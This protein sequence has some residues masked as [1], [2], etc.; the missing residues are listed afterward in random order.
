MPPISSTV[1]ANSKPVYVRPDLSP[2]ERAMESLLLKER[3]SLIEKGVARQ[4]KITNQAYLC[5]TNFIPTYKINNCNA[6]LHPLLLQLKHQTTLFPLTRLL[7]D[8]LQV[9]KVL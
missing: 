4:F 7:I 2:D 8:Y 9:T 6:L 5:S 3:R 1:R